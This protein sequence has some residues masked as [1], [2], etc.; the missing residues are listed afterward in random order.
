MSKI[1]GA[2][3][4][5]YRNLKF[6]ERGDGYRFACRSF[7]SVAPIASNCD[8]S[9]DRKTKR[10]SVIV[11]VGKLRYEVGP[12]ANLAQSVDQGSNLNDMYS[13]SDQYLAL[14]RGALRMMKLDQID[15]LVVGLPVSLFTLRRTELERRLQGHH[16]VGDGKRVSVG[17]VVCI[18]QPVGAFLSYAVPSRQ[19]S[20]MLQERNLIMDPGWKTFDW[21]VTQGL[22]PLDE[23]SDAVNRGM[24]AVV[25]AMARAIGTE[26]N[27]RLTQFDYER[28]D[29]ALRLQTKPRFFGQPRD[30]APYMAAGKR[31]VEDAITEMRLL[32]REASDID[33]ILIAGGGA[34]FYRPEIQKA[35]P[36]HKVLQ[37]DDPLFANVRGFQMFGLEAAGALGANGQLSVVDSVA[38]GAE[39]DA[40]GKAIPMSRFKPV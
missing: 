31:V 7:P 30:L 2:I 18:A 27:C 32:V 8:L 23:R 6:V 12:D 19:R 28:I 33:N 40:T 22:K 26:L 9:V 16:D 39:V 11:P 34:P 37:L 29:E 14:M 13:L 5:G 3:D 25:D 38:E 21:V 15:L 1:V 10:D 24:W 35:F 36:K 17:R 4:L 20:S